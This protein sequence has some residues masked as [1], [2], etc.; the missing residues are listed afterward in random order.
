MPFAPARRRLI[1]GA[2]LG[3]AGLIG[4]V[5]LSGCL[6][7]TADLTIDSDA[8]TTGTVAIGVDKQAASMLGM[9]DLNSFKAGITS[10]DAA[11]AGSGMLAGE[12]CTATETD[13]Q[14]VYTCTLTGS[15]APSSDIP[16]TVTKSG[17]TITFHLVT[18]PSEDSS[19]LL[20]GGSLGDLKVDVTFPGAITSVT[21]D[22][23]TK[24]SDTTI[25]ISAA[26][27]DAVDVTV[28]SAATSGSSLGKILLIVGV[29]A[30]AVILIAL[31]VF[32]IVRGSRKPAATAIGT[33]TAAEVD[34]TT[35]ITAAQ[36]IAVPPPA[37]IEA[38][39]APQEPTSGNQGEPES[40]PSSDPT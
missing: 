20:D 4:V 34:A 12:Q 33:A 27:T 40:P 28:T 25:T 30:A 13:S 14:F 17:D 9:K 10:Q 7:M 5:S 15:E 6:S 38:P 26:M 23:V 37:V 22:K 19:Q 24:D 36:P 2:V 31:V 32:L 39:P 21:G 1:R 35:A 18:K 8:K 11:S 3:I 16:W 29:V